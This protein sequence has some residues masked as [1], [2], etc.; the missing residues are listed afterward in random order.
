MVPPVARTATRGGEVKNARPRPKL[1]GL[2]QAPSQ[3]Q[4]SGLILT[5]FHK[6]IA[7]TATVS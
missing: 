5:G 6:I 1:V 2:L 7:M 3:R 4:G